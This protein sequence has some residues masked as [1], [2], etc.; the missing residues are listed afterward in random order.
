MLLMSTSKNQI[1]KVQEDV[2][3]KPAYEDILDGASMHKSVIK[4]AHETLRHACNATI[5]RCTT[6]SARPHIAWPHLQLLWSRVARSPCRNRS[7]YAL[8]IVRRLLF[9]LRHIIA[10][11]PRHWRAAPN[12]ETG[13]VLSYRNQ[14]HKGP[15]DMLCNNCATHPRT[16][17]DAI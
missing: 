1:V 17:S 10:D 3:D 13:G 14:T 16:D 4:S 9:R 8:S 5:T 6:R 12:A 7:R 15:A 2:L 11:Q